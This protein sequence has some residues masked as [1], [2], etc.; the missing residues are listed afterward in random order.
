MF[1]KACIPE[2]CSLIIAKRS[3]THL[4][5]SYILSTGGNYNNYLINNASG[6]ELYK[7]EG[8][9]LKCGKAFELP[10]MPLR[11]YMH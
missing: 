7:Y 6:Y 8:E 3:L 9:G 11:K 2:N 10:V 1:L 4:K 5:S